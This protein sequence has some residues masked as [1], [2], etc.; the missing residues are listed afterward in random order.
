MASELPTLW[1]NITKDYGIPIEDHK[2]IEL[3]IHCAIAIAEEINGTK[4]DFSIWGIGE[5]NERIR[6]NIQYS[7]YLNSSFYKKLILHVLTK[8]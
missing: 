5:T 2:K 7:Q 6:R 1:P 8:N 4:K 3:L